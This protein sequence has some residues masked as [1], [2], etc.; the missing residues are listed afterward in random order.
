MADFGCFISPGQLVSVYVMK[1]TK[2]TISLHICAG[3]PRFFT[4][5]SSDLLETRDR[6]M[7]FCQ[8]SVVTAR[9][10]IM[11]RYLP[12]TKLSCIFNFSL[13]Y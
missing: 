11:C 4:L 7:I 6:D 12:V 2:P 10:V 13:H 1:N 9:Q 3:F 5:H 8:V